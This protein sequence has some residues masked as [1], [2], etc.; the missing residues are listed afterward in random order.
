MID[1]I[2]HLR[3]VHFTVVMV[4]LAMWSSIFYSNEEVIDKALEQLSVIE[5]IEHLESGFNRKNIQ[6]LREMRKKDNEEYRIRNLSGT[7]LNIGYRYITHRYFRIKKASNLSFFT[8]IAVLNNINIRVADFRPLLG[9]L[10]SRSLSEF[11]RK[12]NDNIGKNT[13]YKLSEIYTGHVLVF[14]NN[15]QSNDLTTAT[16][17]V[18]FLQEMKSKSVSADKLSIYCT[19]IL[20]NNKASNDDFYK[21]Y[22][23]SSSQLSYLKMT[24]EIEYISFFYWCKGGNKEHYYNIFIPFKTISKEEYL[25]DDIIKRENIDITSVREMSSFNRAFP[26][27]VSIT[28]YSRDMSISALFPMLGDEAKRTRRNTT[29]IGI[30]LPQK[31][32]RQ[33]GIAILVSVLVYYILHF[34]YFLSLLD[35]NKVVSAPWIGLYNNKLS[36]IVFIATLCLLPI[37][38]VLTLNYNMLTDTD[39]SLFEI[40]LT[41]LATILLTLQSIYIYILTV[42]YWAVGEV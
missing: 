32:V 24:K 11:E 3:L 19:D 20:P 17:S 21:I 16:K 18:S 29:I 28:K 27:L 38:T 37:T 4:C 8:N 36:K 2:K 23:N 12:W 35:S 6:R 9:K 33:L 5:K 34:Q 31:A 14:K 15:L 1:I 42:R 7:D 41:V 25:I 13:S 10:E 26:E 39:S 30:E 22:K 40:I